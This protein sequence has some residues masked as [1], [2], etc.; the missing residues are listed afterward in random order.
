MFRHHHPGPPSVRH[1]GC[2]TTLP[3]LMGNE[4][5]PPAGLKSQQP[6]AGNNM[7]RQLILLPRP[8][9][10]GGGGGNPIRRLFRRL[11]RC[12]MPDPSRQYVY[13]PVDRKWGCVCRGPGL[14]QGCCRHCI[15]GL[16]E[17]Y[18]LPHHPAPGPIIGRACPS[19]SRSKPSFQTGCA[20][21]LGMDCNPREAQW[22][23]RWCVADR[24]NQRLSAQ[25]PGAWVAMVNW[26]T[27]AAGDIHPPHHTILPATTL[28][29]GK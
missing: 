25:F 24:A 13:M 16:L 14:T 29:T 19:C 17:L 1:Y 18:W 12:H 7:R 5:R 22:K 10:E 3:V 20:C 27:I 6:G 23:G 2:D 4:D 11:S 26:Q 8:A 21:L 28:D 9:G 15:C